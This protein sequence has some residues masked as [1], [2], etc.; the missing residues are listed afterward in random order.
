LRRGAHYSRK[1]L[2]VQ[3]TDREDGLTREVNMLTRFGLWQFSG[4]S[5]SSSR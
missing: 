5:A 3:M 4:C 2:S 1:V